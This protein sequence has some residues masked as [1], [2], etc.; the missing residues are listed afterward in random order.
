MNDHLIIHLH[1]DKPKES[2]CLLWLQYVNSKLT[3]HM[4]V[5]HTNGQHKFRLAIQKMPKS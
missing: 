1:G 5:I 4:L 3:F 2:G